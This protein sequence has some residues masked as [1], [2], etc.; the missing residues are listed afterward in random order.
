MITIENKNQKKQ[1]ETFIEQL[2]SLKDVTV[3]FC[4]TITKQLLRLSY[5]GIEELYSEI[6]D[7]TPLM[8]VKMNATYL[9]QLY[10]ALK[11]YIEKDLIVEMDENLERI[12]KELKKLK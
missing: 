8:Q 7:D 1:I 5:D 12:E 10:L 9:L 3:G 2:N 6:P 11:Q 4:G